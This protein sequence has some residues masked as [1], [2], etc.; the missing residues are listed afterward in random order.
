MKKSV[1]IIVRALLAGS[2]YFS[3]FSAVAEP[4]DS[5]L[6]LISNV[7][8]FDGENEK[9][10]KNMHV[11]V[12]DNL[13]ETISDEPLAII[14]TDNV[15]MI[16]GGGR[17]LMPGLIDAHWHSLFS[18]MSMAKLM[19]SDISYMSLVGAKA[20]E[21]AL[22]RGFTSVRD[23]GGNVF[24][25]KQAADEGLI[26]GP[27]I[28]PSG[29]TI[30]QT[31][32]HG[33][34]RGPLEVPANNGAPLDYLQ[35]E[36]ITIIADGVPAVMQRSREILRKG[37]SQLKVM[38]GGGVS[39]TYDPLDSTQYSFDEMRA[40]VEVANSWNTYVA[41]HAFTD[42]AVRQSVEAGVKS[43]EHGHLLT[44]ETLKLMAE[45]DVWLSMQPILNDEDAILFPP[46][47][48]NQRKFEE[49]TAGTDY[50][51]KTAKKYKVKIAWGT[52]T[53]FDPKLAAKQGKLLAKMKKWFTPFEALK[54]A[55]SDNA[56][57]LAL[58][59]PRNPYQ[60]GPLG[61]IK[62]GAYA[63]LILVDGNPLENLDLVADAA[64]NFDLIMKNG[65]VYKNN[66]E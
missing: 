65:K 55:T 6:T 45:K 13:I 3:G 41:V 1:K 23:V 26:N 37:A 43:I 38:A 32:G 21:D 48:E 56:E 25:L 58:S 15:T 52:D 12:K 28:Y 11:L 49:V 17:T 57:L 64:K 51:Y 33:D 47:S 50:V 66:I 46:E 20:N 2:L 24:A 35:R 19:S 5:K 36:G 8:I 7:N 9:L 16:D 60:Q 53:L 34:F 54:M 10:R 44:D 27:R 63:D 42:D 4:L 40:L 18:S 61:V 29:A 39:S 62:E 30:S 14:Q 31:S 22:M 59:G